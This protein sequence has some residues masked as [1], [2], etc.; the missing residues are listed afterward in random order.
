MQRCHDLV[1][2]LN[3]KKLFFRVART[4]AGSSKFLPPLARWCYYRP[5]A[6]VNP[7][8][9]GLG[10]AGAGLPSPGPGQTGA[11]SRSDCL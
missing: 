7:R 6:P 8:L 11:C 5:P 9:P 1:K 4:P 2:N 3:D 10:K